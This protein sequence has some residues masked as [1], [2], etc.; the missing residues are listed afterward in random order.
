MESFNSKREIGY[1]FT[2]ENFKDGEL[3]SKLKSDYVQFDSINQLWKVNILGPW[4]L[5]KEAWQYLSTNGEGR[6]I[7]LVSMSGKRSKGNLAG[8]PMS[9]FALM[10]ICQ[11][12]RNEGWE[13]G[14]RVTAICPSW[15]N[16]EMASEIQSI[17]KDILEILKYVF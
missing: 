2:L 9:K 6:V 8:Y 10:G 7:F 16:T 14:V 1:K 17:K 3:I 12:M 4:L 13:K 11:T 5:T 15:V